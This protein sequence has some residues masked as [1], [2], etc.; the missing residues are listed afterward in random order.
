MNGKKFD[1]G[2]RLAISLCRC[3][4]SNDKPFCDG[5]HRE[6]GFQSELTARTLPPLT[7]KS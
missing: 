4:S 1:L 6:K 5:S 7:P 2:G 3:G